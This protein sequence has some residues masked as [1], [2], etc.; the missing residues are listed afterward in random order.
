MSSPLVAEV[1]LPQNLRSLAQK[2]D[3]AIHSQN[4]GY[5]VQLLLPVVK[6][7]P[8]FLEGRR[9]LRKAAAAASE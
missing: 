9:K 2:A 4:V 3:A 8:N 1:D 6:A 5:A 7:E